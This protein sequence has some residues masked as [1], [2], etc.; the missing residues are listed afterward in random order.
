MSR[1]PRQVQ[2]QADNAQRLIDE[3]VAGQAGQGKP[4]DA[5]AGAAPAQDEP[6]SPQGTKPG[7]VPANA[8]APAATPGQQKPPADRVDYK[9]KYYTLQGMFNAQNNDLKAA[10]ARIE[11][12]ESKLS[13]GT[14]PGKDA[15]HETAPTATAAPARKVVPDQVRETLGDDVADALQAMFDSNNAE[16]RTEIN[17][18]KSIAERAEN[19]SK[20]VAERQAEDNKSK[21]LTELSKRVPDWTE[22]DTRP[23]WNEFLAQRD[24][25]ARRVRNELMV[26][27]VK[28]GDIEA[29]EAMFKAFKTLAGIPA[30]DA[31]AH[32]GVKPGDGNEKKPTAQERLERQVVPQSAGAAPSRTPD[33]KIWNRAE[34]AKAYADAAMGRIPAD[35]FAPIE[36]DILAAQSEGRITR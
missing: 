14:S 32:P 4:A 35:K 6:S 33:K 20:S 12:L 7:D 18:G 1:L 31:A 30:G 34:I 24:P 10:K 17:A 28:D 29:V 27:A 36:A 16:L 3:F 2:K 25:I 15:H 26:E 23:D 11:D 21:F 13:H 22:I 5:P 8:D 9:A 19:T